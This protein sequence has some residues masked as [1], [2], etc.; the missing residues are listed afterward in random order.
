MTEPAALPREPQPYVVERIRGA[1]VHDP[2]VAELGICVSVLDDAVL[3]TGHV[4]TMERRRAV[5]DVVAP[6]TGGRRLDNRVT[7][8]ALGEAHG[9]ETIT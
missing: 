5:A 2:R 9:E 6:L 7:V 1:L 4:A 8:A 3:I